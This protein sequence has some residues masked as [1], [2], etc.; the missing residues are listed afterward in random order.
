MLVTDRG[1][2]PRYLT[3]AISLEYIILF[4]NITYILHV[5]YT[6]IYMYFYMY[7]TYILLIH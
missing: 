5:F 2:V 1:D 4:K 6:Y 3:D 7:V